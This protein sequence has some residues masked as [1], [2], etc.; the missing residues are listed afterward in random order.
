MERG[1]KILEVGERVAV[2][3]SGTIEAAII[4]TRLTGTIWLGD[5]I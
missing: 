1:R 5:K 3:S 4:A 2:R